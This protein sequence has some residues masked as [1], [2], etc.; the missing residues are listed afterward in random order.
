MYFYT[1]RV[2][3]RGGINDP[4][5]PRNPWDV[6]CGGVGLNV[7]TRLGGVPEGVVSMATRG[8]VRPAAHCGAPARRAAARIDS[9]QPLSG[10]VDFGAAGV[11]SAKGRARFRE[12]AE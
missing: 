7:H 9:P 6:L 3:A 12:S 8:R 11:E 2:D 5:P 1:Q 10:G 4:C